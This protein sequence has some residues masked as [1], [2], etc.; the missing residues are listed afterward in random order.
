MTNQIRVLI[1]EDHQATLKGLHSEIAKEEDL[2]VVGV[3]Q[4]ASEGLEL[5][6]QLRPDVVLLDLHLPD[7]PGP[8]SLSESYCALSD[9]SIIVF[10]GDSRQAIVKLVLETGVRGYLL[11][12]ETVEKVAEA[13][14]N[15]QS[16]ADTVLSAKLMATGEFQRVTAAEEHLLRLLA[17]GMKYKDIGKER[18]TAPETVRKQVEALI[19][20]LSLNSR[21]E[22]IAWAVENGYGNVEI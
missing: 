7:S 22:L 19:E 3:A 14:R 1:V 15:V 2:S 8:R 17:R 12:S 4:T 21:E 11:K 16:G 13:I 5:A 9:V 6:N 20:K 10:S 18:F